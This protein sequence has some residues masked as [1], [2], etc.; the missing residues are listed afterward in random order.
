MNVVIIFH[1]NQCHV[2]L[3]GDPKTFC[4]E[5]KYIMQ[6]SRVFLLYISVNVYLH[7]WMFY[8]FVCIFDIYLFS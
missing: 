3:S 5:H 6:L 7:L 2:N 8:L 1:L 4:K